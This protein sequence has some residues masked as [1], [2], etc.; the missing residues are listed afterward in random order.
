MPPL[1]VDEDSVH[2]LQV[3]LLVVVYRRRDE[4]RVEAT[5]QYRALL[6]SLSV[7]MRK[8]N[9]GDAYLFSSCTNGVRYS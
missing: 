5:R 1:V 6:E 8:V 9:D 2:I 7:E 4:V 3:G